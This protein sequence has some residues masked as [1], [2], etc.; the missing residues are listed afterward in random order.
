[1]VTGD[2]GHPLVVAVNYVV[3]ELKPEVVCVAIH[4]LPMEVLSAQD[5]I[6][7]LSLAILRLVLVCKKYWLLHVLSLWNVVVCFAV[8]FWQTN[9]KNNNL[10]WGFSFLF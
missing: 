4:H 6:V 5:Q 9:H 10:D 1:M 7:N 8:S 3:L 2:L